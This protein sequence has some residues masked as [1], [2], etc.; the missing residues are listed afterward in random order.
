MRLC[1]S[2]RVRVSV[3]LSIVCLGLAGCGVGRVLSNAAYD[4]QHLE[5]GRMNPF[6][7]D[8]PPVRVEGATV[9]EVI[10]ALPDV[11]PEDTGS[12]RAAAPVAAE[13]GHAAKAGHAAAGTASAAPSSIGVPVAVPRSS[14]AL[15]EVIA[16][17]EQ[18]L[19]ALSDEGARF[20]VQKRVT[21]LKLERAT[22]AS[23]PVRYAEVIAAYEQLLRTVGSGAGADAASTAPALR[24]Q[25]ARA[26]DL[27]GQSD[28]ALAD[29]DRIIAEA[30]PAT[31]VAVL[32]EAHF[33]RAEAAFARGAYTV[34]ANDY[35]AARGADSKYGLHAGYMLGWSHFRSGAPAKAL[36][37]FYEVIALIG[38]RPADS[39][40]GSEQEMLADVLRASVLALERTGGVTTLATSMRERGQPSWQALLY[41]AVGSFYL[42]GKRFQDAAN[43]FERYEQENALAVAAP[44]FAL[45]AID[46]LT[47]GAFPTEVA[48][49]KPRF[50]ER[51]GA[52]SAFHDAHGDAGILPFALP[53]RAF[54][55]EQTALMHSQAQRDPSPAAYA[56]AARWYRVWLANFDRAPAPPSTPN[57]GAAGAGSVTATDVEIGEH[58]FLLGETL[59]AGEQLAAA[60]PIMRGLV[61]RMPAHP[62]AREAGYATV[63]ALTTLSSADAS[64]SAQLLAA[65][66]D[67]ADRFGD[68][69]R[70]PDV[71]IHA[72][73]S[74]L[75][76]Q[77]HEGAALA[78]ENALGRWT[79]SPVRAGLAH[80]IAAEGRLARAELPAAEAHFAAARALTV[81]PA[82]QGELQGRLL[83]TVG[84]QAELAEKSGD[85]AAA[86]GH[87]QR[88]TGIAPDSEL[89]VAGGLNV[90]SLYLQ[91]GNLAAAAAQLES[92]RAAHPE[93]ALV[94]DVA[95][96]LADIYEKLQQPDK[97]A[98]ELMR[99]A[100]STPDASQA[101]AAHYHATELLLPVDVA[102]AERAIAERIRVAEQV[103]ISIA[104]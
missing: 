19:P 9:A 90:A 46:A 59:V 49:R 71:Q 91:S 35:A 60:V 32:R 102:G 94:R 36:A 16:R 41:D 1:T 89:A 95:L 62:R 75:S 23:D 65:E 5:L 37:A 80:R 76:R 30:V 99:V 31:D 54:I 88:L 40:A 61:R 98:G 48:L 2:P 92:A 42:Q 64:L 58:I 45:R 15:D 12:Q 82:E 10:A 25:L 7:D 96:R 87:L 78:A 79:L 83:S 8:L 86:I 47:D 93:H 67:F 33:R 4:L 101:R 73:R 103:G 77:D 21:D 52:G 57:L 26:R 22:F 29:L 6:S 38:S 55:E 68:D 13:A 81:D 51:Y 27:A 74:L 69:P 100:R 85:I 66:L 53:L 14:A 63:L 72:A 34:A 43:A 104:A 97:A 24:Y 18:V 70:A 44:K 28:A 20:A 39:L 84:Q 17:Y 56:E 11:L 3:L 50:V